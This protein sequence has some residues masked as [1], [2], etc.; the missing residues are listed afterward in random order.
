M[1]VGDVVRLWRLNDD[2]TTRSPTD[3]VGVVVSTD[4]QFGGTKDVFVFM[5]GK[6]ER[7]HPDALRVIS[8]AR[9]EYA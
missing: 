9:K 7:Y 8:A 2:Y 3:R 5:H 6:R 1:K 4:Y